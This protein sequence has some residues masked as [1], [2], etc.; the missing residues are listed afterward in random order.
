[1]GRAA[2]ASSTGDAAVLDTPARRLVVGHPGRRRD[3]GRSGR[4]GWRRAAVGHGCAGPA[5][6]IGIRGWPAVAR[7][8][9]GGGLGISTGPRKA[10]AR[11]ETTK[12][13]PKC[14][15]GDYTFRSR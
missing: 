6:G 8:L 7:T 13:Y 14:G 10:D 1:A 15:R 3:D 5:L 2:Q 4:N 9:A 12:T 11:M